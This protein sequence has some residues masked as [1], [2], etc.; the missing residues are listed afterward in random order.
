M[1][2]ANKRLK[3]QTSEYV[4]LHSWIR[5]TFGTPNYCEHCECTTAKRFQWANLDGVYS[6]DRSAWARLCT[7]CH[8]KYDRRDS[9][10]ING[11][12]FTQDNTYVRPAGNPECRTCRSNTTKKYFYENLR[13]AVRNRSK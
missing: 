7:S 8:L 9:K 3:P 1:K 6:K 4:I 10:C 13:A 11:H 12:E 5:K 2:V